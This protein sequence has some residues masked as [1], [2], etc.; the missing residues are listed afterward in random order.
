M[1]DEMKAHTGALMGACMRWILIITMMGVF[2][3]L[4]LVR[5]LFS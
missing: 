1:N 5:F 4:F 2:V 3:E